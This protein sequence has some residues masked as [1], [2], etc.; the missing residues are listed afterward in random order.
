[1]VSHFLLNFFL[2]FH[3]F[4]FFLRRVAA[5]VGVVCGMWDLSSL[6]RDPT[7]AICI[8]SSES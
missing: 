7:H 2:L 4:F 1:M 6:I 3:V 5:G 8:R